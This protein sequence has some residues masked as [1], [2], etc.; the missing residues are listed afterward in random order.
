MTGNDWEARRPLP[1]DNEIAGQRDDETTGRRDDETTR[2]RDCE[3]TGKHRRS[4]AFSGILSRAWLCVAVRGSLTSE[5]CRCGASQK[6]VPRDSTK[7]YS[8]W[9]STFG[10]VPQMR[11][12]HVKLSHKAKKRRPSKD[13]QL[14]REYR[15]LVLVTKRASLR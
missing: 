9:Y 1:R 2:L 15:D 14:A 6:R 4:Q 13:I 12:Y 8:P 11:R 7:A 3:T 5:W 10:D